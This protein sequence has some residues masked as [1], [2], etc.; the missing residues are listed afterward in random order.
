MFAG[1]SDADYPIFNT[2][3]PQTIAQTPERSEQFKV[4][5]R[6]ELP[7]KIAVSSSL[8]QATRQNVFD[9]DTIP[10]PSGPGNIDVASFFD[11][12]VSG[13]ENDLNLNFGQWNFIGNLTIQRPVITTYPTPADVG[14]HVPSVP[15]VL[16]NFWTTYDF[17]LPE[18]IPHLR[19]ALGLQ[20][21]GKEFS[22]VGQTRIIPGAPVV[23]LALQMHGDRVSLAVGVNNVLDQRYFM[24]GAGTGGGAYPG[25]GRSVYARLSVALN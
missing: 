18:P 25:E 2:E 17:V 21:Q 23:S 13:W 19:A 10:N 20:Y 16:A 1:Y 6:Y 3:E 9:L 4:G 12:R 22:D 24:Y 7:S 15:S 11:Y 8:F 5:L 14:N